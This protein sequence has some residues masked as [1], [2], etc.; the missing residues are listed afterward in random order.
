MDDIN[1]TIEGFAAGWLAAWII[2]PF[3]LHYFRR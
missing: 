3:V 2:A 1:I